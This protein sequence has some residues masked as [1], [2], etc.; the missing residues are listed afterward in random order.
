MAVAAHLPVL[1]GVGQLTS[2]WVAADGGGHA[3]SP[4]SLRRDAALA[5]IADTGASGMAGVAAAIDRVIVVRTMLDSVA[6][7]PHPFGRCAN[8]PGTLAADAGISGAEAIYSVVGGDQPQT[9]VEEAAAAIHSGEARAILLAGAEATGAMKAA[10]RAGLTLDWS[11]SVEGDFED[12]GLGAALLSRY[13]IGNGLGAPTQTYPAFEH[14][15][16]VRLGHDRAAHRAMMSR[17]W[18]GFSAVA[19][20]NP[21]AQFPTRQDEAFLSTPSADNYPV[22]DPYLK[23][24][25]AQDAVNQGAAL[26]LMRSDEAD[27]LGIAADK[28]VYLHGHAHARDRTPSE[29]PD[30]GRSLATELVLAQAL[31]ESG[32]AGA[33]AFAHIDLYSCFPVA[34]LLAAEVLGLPVETEAQAARLT[35]TG[36]LPFFGGAGNNYSMHAIATMVERLRA[37]PGA[38]GLILAN[39]GFLS[40]EAAGVYSTRPPA[41][42]QPQSSAAIQQACDDQQGPPLLTGDGEGVLESFTVTYSKGEAQRGYAFLRTPDG[43]RILARTAKGDAARLATATRAGV[44]S[45]RM[46]VRVEEGVN[47]LDL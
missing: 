14:A 35:V 40:K 31:R 18:A 30:L 36:G 21:Y 47:L 10:L 25:V 24:D 29:R 44:A 39:G 5:A 42:W 6:G 43:A 37:E 45:Q 46:R 4:Q 15:L 38:L 9:L 8:P 1:V 22:A 13:E 16:A 27:R 41:N 19:A 3:P 12:R 20:A 32:V 28:R 23:W 11:R 34:V 2:H 7:A 26:I 33:D 17:L